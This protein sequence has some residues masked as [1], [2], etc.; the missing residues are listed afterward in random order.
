MSKAATKE[1]VKSEVPPSERLL[2]ENNR[3][4]LR[5][6]EFEAPTSRCQ[7][8]MESTGMWGCLN[9]SLRR[10]WEPPEQKMSLPPGTPGWMLSLRHDAGGSDVGG[11]SFGG[12]YAESPGN[13]Y[14]TS[15]QK[16]FNPGYLRSP[17]SSELGSPQRL[18]PAPGVEG[19]RPV[20]ESAGVDDMRFDYADQESWRPQMEK[21]ASVPTGKSN[22]TGGAVLSRASSSAG[23]SLPAGRQS[24]GTPAKDTLYQRLAKRRSMGSENGSARGS[25]WPAGSPMSARMSG[26][27]S[28]GKQSWKM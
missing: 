4:M 10:N 23:A 14:T 18:R 3:S 5:R 25:P 12:D 1:Y 21:S 2:K 9:H 8:L 11:E 13:E 28:P 16:Y 7:R 6:F 15:N 24:V 27:D 19:L 26:S 17:T 20:P 22:G